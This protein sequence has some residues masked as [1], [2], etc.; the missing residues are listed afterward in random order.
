MTANETAEGLGLK[1]PEQRRTALP[2][3]KAIVLVSS[4]NFLEMYDFMV[5]GYYAGS[6][7]K[8][9]FP[10]QSSFASLM[11]AFMTFGA[12]YLMR[13]IGAVLLGAYVDKHG[14]RKGLVL[15]LS[16]MAIGTLAIALTP[17]YGQIGMAAP[18]LVVMARLV[19]GFSAGVEVGGVSVYLAE[20]A[21]PPR[22]AFYV[23][24]QSASQQVAVVFAAALGLALN[25]FLSPDELDSWGWRLPF[26][27]GCL[28]IPLLVMLRRQLEETDVFRAQAEPPTFRQV[29]GEIAQNSLLV[30]K[31]MMLVAMTTVFFY[32]ITA[33]TPTFGSAVLKLKPEA[34]FLVTLCVGATN[35]TLL[36]VMGAVSDRIGRLPLLVTASLLATVSAYPALWW[37]VH[38]PDFLKLL[39]AEIYFAIIFATYNAAMVPF[40]VEAMPGR[41]RTASFSLA[42]SLATGLLGGFTPAVATFLI[43]LTGNRAAPGAWLSAAA[44]MSICGL[45]GLRHYRNAGRSMTY[46]HL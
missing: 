36:P 21:P 41:V 44:L 43:H 16:L 25:A 15:T 33:Y 14:R 29:F 35:F 42:F 11:L 46:A 3:A 32:M 1:R 38:E 24:W 27:I 40:L 20:I 13:P 23:A 18:V 17:S 5:F 19:Q 30:L 2:V 8:V 39:G 45:I 12:G 31:G 22:R 7:A 37:L 34:S 6:I 10:L 26:V 9:F 28:L 4:G